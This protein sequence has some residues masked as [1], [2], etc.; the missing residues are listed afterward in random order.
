MGS[1]LKYRKLHT[2]DVVLESTIPYTSDEHEQIH[3]KNNFVSRDPSHIK[4]I[5]DYSKNSTQ[6]NSYLHDKHNNVPDRYNS[7]GV[8]DKVKTL[9]DAINTAKIKDHIHVFTGLKDSPT[10]FFNGSDKE[11]KDV[12]LPAFTS[13]TTSR[14]TAIKF[15]SGTDD[16]TNGAHGI[17]HDTHNRHI[18]KIHVPAGTS[19]A[20]IIEH[21]MIPEEKEILLNRGHNISID[22]I[23][24]KISDNIYQWNA[25]ITSHTPK[26]L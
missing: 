5:S 21:A 13:T 20:S 17:E 3:T 10:R 8:D 15:A 18:L 25:R 2:Q 6:I 9:T 12:H 1:F 16:N 11:K 26:E 24:D 14:P 22:P 23:P 4:A 7:V 19:G